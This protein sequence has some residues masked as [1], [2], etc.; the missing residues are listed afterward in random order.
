ME[1]NV[2][3]ELTTLSGFIVKYRCEKTIYKEELYRLIK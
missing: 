2:F 1:E 3:L